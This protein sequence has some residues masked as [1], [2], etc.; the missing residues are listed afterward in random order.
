MPWLPPSMGHIAVGD[1]Q[2][3]ASMRRIA[4]DALEVIARDREL[5]QRSADLA[6]Q[7]KD[8]TLPLE[9]AARQISQDGPEVASLLDR[10]PAAAREVL[11]WVLLTAIQ[12]IA[13]QAVADLLDHSATPADVK[14]I[15]T[16]HDRDMQREC[17]D[18]VESALR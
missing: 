16:Q 14:Q 1:Q 3:Q 9:E 18:A 4:I 11:I 5:F 2:Q 12:I 13:T 8:G 17:E 7:T 15:I 10:V 6:R